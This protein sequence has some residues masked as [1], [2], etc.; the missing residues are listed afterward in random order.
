MIY[1]SAYYNQNG[2][3]CPTCEKGDVTINDKSDSAMNNANLWSVRHVPN[4]VVLLLALSVG[5]TS[6]LT[7]YQRQ[8][9]N[10]SRQHLNEYKRS[11]NLAFT[12]FCLLPGSHKTLFLSVSTFYLTFYT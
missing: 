5:H 6:V 10:V 8:G 7:Y 1:V 2:F 11:L 4:Q 9:K 12:Q 3:N